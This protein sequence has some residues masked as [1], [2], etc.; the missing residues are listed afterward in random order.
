MLFLSHEIMELKFGTCAIVRRTLRFFLINYLIIS[1]FLYVIERRTRNHFTWLNFKVSRLLYQNGRNKILY[2]YKQWHIRGKCNKNK[3]GI[4]KW[5]RARFNP[6]SSIF[7][8][9]HRFYFITFFYLL[10]PIFPMH[11]FR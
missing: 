3:I 10:Y 6:L 5:G 9:T 2:C 11:Q 4:G 7:V 1:S 8:Y